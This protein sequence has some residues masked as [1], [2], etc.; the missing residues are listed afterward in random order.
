M[1]LNLQHNDGVSDPGPLYVE[2]SSKPDFSRQLLYLEA[3]ALEGKGLT[4][5]LSKDLS[6]N[7]NS[8]LSEAS[9][10]GTQRVNVSTTTLNGE[11]EAEKSLY[12]NG[13]LRSDHHKDALSTHLTPPSSEPVVPVETL[14]AAESSAAKLHISD[15]GKKASPRRALDPEANTYTEDLPE[16]EVD[17]GR[18]GS[19]M[20]HQPEHEVDVGRLRQES[21]EEGEAV[22]SSAGSSTLQGEIPETEEG[23]TEE[24]EDLEVSNELY[25]DEGEIG[26]SVPQPDIDTSHDSAGHSSSNQYTDYTEVSIN[27]DVPENMRSIGD[28]MNIP[29]ETQDLEHHASGDNEPHPQDDVHTAGDEAQANEST[30]K[31]GEMDQDV[32]YGQEYDNNDYSA[33]TP[34]Q[35]W[36]EE[37][38]DDHSDYEQPE[39]DP[40]GSLHDTSVRHASGAEE[41]PSSQENLQESKELKLF[42]DKLDKGQKPSSDPIDATSEVSKPTALPDSNLQPSTPNSRKRPLQSDEEEYLIEDFES[43]IVLSRIFDVYH[44]NYD[45]VTPK[46]VKST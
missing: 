32:D 17:K 18:K 23:L 39:Q 9:E 25:V 6:E 20:N 1:Y 5:C 46:R 29:I 11:E 28:K 24:L 27:A 8:V 14:K 16:H 3:S 7:G 45:I 40:V 2:L 34:Y 42:E 30:Q 21:N 31:A 35:E 19:S 22:K 33:E 41:T 13:N 26:D 38:I 12:N 43:E 4:E 36:L 37:G 15:E 44:T 10:S